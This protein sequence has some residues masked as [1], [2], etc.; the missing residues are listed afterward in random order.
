[1][2]A[3]P[4][5]SLLVSVRSVAEA[6]AA[7]AGGAALIDVKEPAAGSLG[8][9]ADET[10]AAVIAWADGRRPVSAAL[11]ELRDNPAPVACAGLSYAKWGL[12]GCGGRGDWCREL[13]GAARRL[14]QADP[15][16]KLVPV[17]Y[18][19]WQRAQAPSPKDVCQFTGAHAC[20]AMLIDTWQ[21]DGTT[22][23]D[24]LR[25]D[26]VMHL[27]WTAPVPVALAGSLGP[28]EVQALLPARPAWFAVR[29]A[30]CGGGRGGTVERER[31]ARLVTLLRQDSRATEE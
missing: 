8:R 5:P 3:T 30:V 15:E 7:A 1:M 28:N 29:G 13:A 2:R 25:L 19:D 21:K 6:E 20:G 26:E 31:V 22:L 9:A 12:A 17:A 14:Q 24:W 16:C 18:A 27:C 23:L 4:T 10:I 11:G